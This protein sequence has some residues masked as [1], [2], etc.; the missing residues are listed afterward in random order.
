MR[1]G[2]PSPPH[3]PHPLKKEKKRKGRSF[4]L[5]PLRYLSEYNWVWAPPYRCLHVPLLRRRHTFA[6]LPLNDALTATLLLYLSRRVRE[7]SQFLQEHYLPFVLSDSTM[8]EV[9]AHLCLYPCSKGTVLQRRNFARRAAFVRN[10]GSI[11]WCWCGVLK[12]K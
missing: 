9:R 2:A 4:K 5:W 12:G 8:G 10:R 6:S 7:G 3:P 1:C 11:I